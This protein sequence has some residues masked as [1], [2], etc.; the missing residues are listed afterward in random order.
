MSFSPF[1]DCFLATGSFDGD[2]RILFCSILHTNQVDLLLRL[3]IS[4]N[5][6]K[7]LSLFWDLLY[8]N[9][10]FIIACYELM[11][12]LFLNRSA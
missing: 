7:N 6:S 1:D 9:A 3:K 2:V 11:M 10:F 8:L 4:H 12:R 5:D